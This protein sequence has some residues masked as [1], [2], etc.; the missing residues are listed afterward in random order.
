MSSGP[1]VSWG[2]RGSFLL[3]LAST[4]AAQA[5]L[6]ALYETRQWFQLREAIEA[7]NPSPL[8]RGAVALAFN[9]TQQAEKELREVIRAAPDSDD[10][11]EA[12]GLLMYLYMRSGQS[13]HALALFD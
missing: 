9:H 12:H 5:D 3:L 1:N 2:M 6:K 10:A 4:C 7:T 13:R 8:Y 11:G